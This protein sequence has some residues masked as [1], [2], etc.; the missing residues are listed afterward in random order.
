MAE[1]E[2]VP[3]D[4][5]LAEALVPAKGA[6]PDEVRAALLRRVAKAARKQGLHHLAAQKYA[7][8]RRRCPACP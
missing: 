3:L 2:A 4:D 8:V 1:R 5:D 6:A 7:Q